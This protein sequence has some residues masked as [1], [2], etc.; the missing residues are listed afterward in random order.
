MSLTI[1]RLTHLRLALTE[2]LRE[3]LET[4]IA[5]HKLSGDDFLFAY[6]TGKPMSQN[7]YVRRQLKTLGKKIGAPGLDFRT[8]RRSFATYCRKHGDPKDLQSAMRHSDVRMSLEVYTQ[9]LPE[10]TFE[11]VC[12]FE[13]EVMA[14]VAA[15]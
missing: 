8:L 15:A 10:Q 5:T 12:S 6:E 2:D 11:T 9:D 13:R 3:C 4:Y 14:L 1:R 7:N